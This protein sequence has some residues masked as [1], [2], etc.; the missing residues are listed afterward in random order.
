MFTEKQLKNFISYRHVQMSGK[1]N[2]F[3][4]GAGGATG[5]TDKEFTFVM[6]NYIPL[7]DAVDKP[8]A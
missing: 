2:R 7:R 6:D 5:L 3:D 8:Q 4:P 1:W